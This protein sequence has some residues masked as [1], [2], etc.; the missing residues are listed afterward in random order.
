MKDKA[1]YINGQ[2]IYQQ[3]GNVLTYFFKTG[4]IKAK[5]KFIK[6]FME[7]KWIFNRENGQLWQ[8]GNF[9]KGIKNGNWVRYNKVCT[10]EHQSIYKEGKLIKPN[11]DSTLPNIGTPAK[12][13]LLSINV[14]RLEQVSKYSK[15]QLL[16]LHGLGPKAI[17]ILESSLKIKGL[18]FKK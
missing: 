14:S 4:I 16:G 2:K 15:S 1:Y 10:L 8:V 18:S 3:K 13:A 7:G 6:G 5:G 12:R 17:A 11:G 9:K